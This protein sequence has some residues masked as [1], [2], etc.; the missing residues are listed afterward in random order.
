M[1]ISSR[2]LDLT[3]VDMLNAPLL[4]VFTPLMNLEPDINRHDAPMTLVESMSDMTCPL[5][6]LADIDDNEKNIARKRMR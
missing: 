6:V 5:I 1:D 2:R 4:S 3:S